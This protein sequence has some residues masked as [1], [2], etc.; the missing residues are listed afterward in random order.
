MDNQVNIQQNV[1]TNDNETKTVTEFDYTEMGLDFKKTITVKDGTIKKMELDKFT[2]YLVNKAAENNGVVYLDSKIIEPL[3]T[4]AKTLYLKFEGG[5]NRLVSLQYF[6]NAYLQEDALIKANPGVLK[7]NPDEKAHLILKRAGI[8]TN[9]PDFKY[10]GK[11]IDAKM[12]K[13]Y[14]SCKYYKSTFH[15]AEYGLFYFIEDNA[16]GVCSKENDYQTIIPFEESDLYNKI[17]LPD[18]MYYLQFKVGGFT[19]NKLITNKPSLKCEVT[20]ISNYNKLEFLDK[21]RIKVEEKYM[22]FWDAAGIQELEEELETGVACLAFNELDKL[23]ESQEDQKFKITFWNSAEEGL[24]EIYKVF[25]LKKDKKAEEIFLKVLEDIET[26]SIKALF[27]KGILK[28][29]KSTL[30]NAAE[31]KWNIGKTQYRIYCFINGTNLYL[32]VPFIKSN[33]DKDTDKAGDTA[34]KRFNSIKK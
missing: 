5:R 12:Y 22:T 20:T 11:K 8:G 14:S 4:F 27:D 24:A 10:N 17:K 2:N 28:H 23:Y 19:D 3:L 29:L 25:N 1:E 9:D 16:W 7:Y 32:M 26:L 6:L 15:K 30:K 18:N 13:N 33:G 31:I 21:E 34:I